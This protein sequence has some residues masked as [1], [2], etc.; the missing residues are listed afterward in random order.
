MYKMKDKEG[1]EKR[2]REAEG[3]GEVL[4]GRGYSRAN[5]QQC[6]WNFPA[7]CVTSKQATVQ[8]ELPSKVCDLCQICNWARTVTGRSCSS[9]SGCRGRGKN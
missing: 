2:R 8:M 9:G 6:R 1:K 4:I 7:R 3:A 5:R